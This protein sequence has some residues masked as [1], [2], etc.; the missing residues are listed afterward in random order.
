MRRRSIFA[1][2]TFAA[3]MGVAQD[4]VSESLRKGVVEEESNHNLDAAIQDYRAAVA[5]FDQMR[6][7]AATALFR[8]AE[9]YRK[10]GQQ[11]PATEA[12]RRVVQEFPDQ[13]KLVEESQSILKNT[14]H[15]PAAELQADAKRDNARRVY[16]DTLEKELALVQKECDRVNGL[17]QD[18]VLPAEALVEAQMKLLQAQR[19]LA[20]F[21][22]GIPQ[23]AP[24]SRH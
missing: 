18:T 14:L 20:A 6:Q 1:M 5:Q 7:M 15:V 11:G 2:L 12:Y 16:R 3:A 23:S 24:G 13:G 21:D 17:V 4:R 10:Q 8:M 19:Q 22:A 9:C